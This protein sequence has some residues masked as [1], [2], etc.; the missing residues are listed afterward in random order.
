MGGYAV[1]EEEMREILFSG[2]Y[3]E[4]DEVVVIGNI[5]DNPGLLQGE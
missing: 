5:F 4:A 2:V 3:I 1:Q